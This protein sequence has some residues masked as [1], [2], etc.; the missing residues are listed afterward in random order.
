M[1]QYKKSIKFYIM[2]FVTTFAILGAYTLY[3][4]LS[5]TIETADY[6]NLGLLPFIFTL[7]Y[8]GGDTILQKIANRKKKVDYEGRFLD[9]IGE[10]MR[11][12]D[13]FIIEDYRRL[14]NNVKFQDALKIA[15]YI[16]QNGENENINLDKLERKFD[17]R[18]IEHKAMTYAII[19]VKE[20]LNEL[21][22]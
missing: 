12:T 15:F 13:D 17:R 7:V 14:Q 16:Y 11:A 20:K 5:G 10:K 4:L 6:L 8:W 19:F 2:L 1:K 9:A 21:A 3:K 18:T 22:K